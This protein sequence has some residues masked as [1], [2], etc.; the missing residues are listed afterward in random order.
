MNRQ[1]SDLAIRLKALAHPVRLQ[2]VDC[3][4]R[5]ELCVCQMESAL[6]KR[7]AYISQHLMVLREAGL[8]EARRDGLL[9]YYHLSDPLTA[10]LLSVALGPVESS[11]KNRSVADLEAARLSIVSAKTRFGT[12]ER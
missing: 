6:G 11:S 12:R 1:Y 7:Q 9:V 4:R 2:I 3:L 5:H 10:E 8:V